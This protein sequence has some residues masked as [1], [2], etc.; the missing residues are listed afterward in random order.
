MRS[1]SPGGIKAGAKDMQTIMAGYLK[2]PTVFNPCMGKGSF[3]HG[4]G[5][6]E[7]QRSAC[8]QVTFEDFCR[9][10]NFKSLENVSSLV[11]DILKTLTGGIFDLNLFET[12]FSKYRY[13]ING[14]FN[15][16]L[17]I[18]EN[19][20]TYLPKVIKNYVR[21]SC[22]SKR[23]GGIVPSSTET[24]L[25]QLLP[26]STEASTDY[27]VKHYTQDPFHILNSVKATNE[28]NG[29]IVRRITK[30]EQE[31]KDTPGYKKLPY[32]SRNNSS[33]I[34]VEELEK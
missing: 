23:I 34:D 24:S 2:I 4:D 33:I 29:K 16:T 22:N 18:K 10:I 8:I 26:L 13:A 32:M 17:K 21:D 11:T 30:K 9:Y 1:S 25:A 3:L 28:F 12:E 19:G 15:G 7:K 5:T 6:A 20:R 14:E 27:K 31:E